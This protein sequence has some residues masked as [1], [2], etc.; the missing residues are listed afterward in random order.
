MRGDR[1]ADL[2][3]VP[4]SPADKAGLVENDIILEINGEKITQEHGL[5]RLLAKYKPDDRVR[6]KVY[7]KGEETEVE[8]ILVERE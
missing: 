8:A 1:R 6:L 5:A 7:H 3:V 4:A 2:A